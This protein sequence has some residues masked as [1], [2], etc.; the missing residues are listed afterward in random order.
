MPK[1]LRDQLKS[2]GSGGGGG[3]GGDGNGN[4]GTRSF[5]TSARLSQR[6]D[7]EQPYPAEEEYARMSEQDEEHLSAEED[8]ASAQI[9]Q[10]QKYMDDSSFEEELAP[11]PS[12]SDALSQQ[13]R[14]AGQQPAGEDP[15]FE[16]SM[17]QLVDMM[18]GV[19]E[20]KSPEQEKSEKSQSDLTQK[21]TPG[22]S[23][24]DRMSTPHQKPPQLQGVE[25]WLNEEE[26]PASE[27]SRADVADMMAAASG[28]KPLE[29]LNGEESKQ[30]GLKFDPPA[31]P[32]PRTEHLRHRYDPV[33]DH[34]TKLIMWSGKLAQAQR[35]RQC[36]F[37]LGICYCEI[38]FAMQPTHWNF[39]C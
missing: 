15:E 33:V 18:A 2:S 16:Q 12:T 20:N 27:P 39:A 21:P 4:N 11:E 7:P 34:F 8:Y 13:Q 3:G 37:F 23:M 19:S 9:F 22:T 5:S 24:P 1:V 31:M 6:R 35:V 14:D 26:G 36:G 17:D 25:Q 32:L 38:L 10:Q 30:E 29:E 28:E